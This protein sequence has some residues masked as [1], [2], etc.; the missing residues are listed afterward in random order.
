MSN[1]DDLV[2][3]ILTYGTPCIMTKKLTPINWDYINPDGAF[4]P[5]AA[6]QRFPEMIG[7]KISDL[8]LKATEYE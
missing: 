3:A 4:S 6:G 1:D 5:Y 7:K 8:F 2:D